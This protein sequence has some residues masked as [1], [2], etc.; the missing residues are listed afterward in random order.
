MPPSP[1]GG[2]FY[3]AAD[4]RRSSRG[5]HP[6]TN[7]TESRQMVIL[8]DAEFIVAASDTRQRKSGDRQS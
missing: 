3:A 6:E 4:R 7:L 5:E 8:Q 2:G 1:Q